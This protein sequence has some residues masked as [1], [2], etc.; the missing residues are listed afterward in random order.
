MLNVSSEDA[1]KD[2]YLISALLRSKFYIQGLV[3]RNCTNPLA[4]MLSSFMQVN[5]S[6]IEQLK[7][8]ST[9]YQ[10]ISLTDSNMELN[11]VT[12]RDIDVSGDSLI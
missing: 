4:F 2:K 6:L 7:V 8:R 5:N 3:V 12:I 1:A 10:P 11:N 9:L